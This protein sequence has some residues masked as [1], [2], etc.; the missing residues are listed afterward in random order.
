MPKRV[1]RAE[2]E[3][4]RAIVYKYEL[5]HYVEPEITD[6]IVGQL[7][8]ANDAWNLHTQ[9]ERE[10]DEG[11]RQFWASHKTVGPLM[12]A[13]DV[14]QDEVD[15]HYAAI[16][17]QK[18]HDRSATPDP[19]L[20]T[21]LKEAR[22]KSTASREAFKSARNAAR[23]HVRGDL[24]KISEVR[25]AA[26]KHAYK[27]A[28][29]SGLYWATFNIVAA[30]HNI[31]N[32]QVIKA[33]TR[34]A[35][36][37][38]QFHRWDGTGTLRVQLQREEGDPART[39]EM[40][41]MCAGSRLVATG[42]VEVKKMAAPA[43]EFPRLIEVCFANCPHCDRR[44]PLGEDGLTS[45]HYQPGNKWRNMLS[46]EQP[47]MDPA[48]WAATPRKD[49]IHVNVKFRVGQGDQE[50]ILTLPIRMHRQIPLDADIAEVQLTRRRTGPDFRMFMEFM[51][52][53]PMPP[54]RAEGE[55]AA[56]HLGWRV[57]PSG[58]IRVAVTTTP[59]ARMLPMDLARN[60][61]VHYH[62][63][64]AEVVIPVERRDHQAKMQDLQSKRD[65][66]TGETKAWLQAWVSEHPD[67]KDAIDPGGKL[68]AWRSAGA[69]SNLLRDL[70]L[71]YTDDPVLSEVITHLEEWQEYDEHLWRWAAWGGARDNRKRLDAFRHFSAWLCQDAAMVIVDQWQITNRTPD[72]TVAETPREA[73]ARANA[74][75]AS[76]GKFRE[77]MEKAAGKVGARVMEPE[78]LAYGIHTG[79]G[80][81][82]ARNDRTKS[83]MVMCGGCGNMVDQDV[84]VLRAQILAATQ[85]A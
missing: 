83:V 10:R 43:G 19:E 25:D 18:Q 71:G 44:V 33:R 73:R 62:G 23:P 64:W 31:A 16:R 39:L 29:E 42:E 55:L 22:D 17:E 11:E 24:M 27:V 85:S 78:E 3:N 65:K 2:R 63:D 12:A 35:R 30:H 14:A 72:I 81:E 41:S 79:C 28:T 4:L 37:E 82:L 80:G 49:R 77:A 8:L 60:G 34:G 7:H 21:Q 69:F 45:D 38:M 9:I 40:L 46:I 61:Y 15:R 56:A 32:K 13:R 48:T 76:P 66:H 6:A 57:L 52:L 47:F 74:R 70:M 50:T 59:R 58:D 20:V 53:V 1:S 26:R 54:A 84:N 36:A 67:R 68:H 75:L 51:I 5:A